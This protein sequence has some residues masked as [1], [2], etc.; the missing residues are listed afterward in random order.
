MLLS[1]AMITKNEEKNIFRSLQALKRLENKIEYEIVVVDTGSTDNTIEIAKK[2]TDKV[3]KHPWTG[4]FAEMRNISISYCQG[5]WI[6]ILDADEVIESTDEI[7]DFLK[8]N[9]SEIYNCMTLKSKNIVTKNEDDYIIMDLMRL[10]KNHKDFRYKGRV[11]EQPFLKP[12]IG[13]SRI[14]FLHYGYCRADYN[15]MQYKF[16]RNLELLLKD[17]EEGNK[18]IYNYFQVAQTYGMSEKHSESLEYIKIAYNMIGN[19]RSEEKSYLY[20]NH[21]YSMMEYTVGN[22]ERAIEL[23]EEALNFNKDHL[24]FYFILISAYMKMAKYKEADKYCD[25]YLKLHDKLS[26]G[27]LVNDVSVPC[28]T[29]CKKD[30]ILKNKILCNYN[31]KKFR[32][33]PDLFKKIKKENYIDELKEIY[34]FSLLKNKEYAEVYAYLKNIKFEDKDIQS[35]VN[36]LDRFRNE[37]EIDEILTNINS[38]FELDDRLNTLRDVLYKKNIDAYFD[39]SIELETYFPWKSKYLMELLNNNKF[40]LGMLKESNCNNIVQYVTNFVSDYK[41]I[42]ILCKYSKTHFYT[43]DLKMLNLITSI[44][45]VLVVNNSINSKEYHELL[46]RARINKLNYINII[47]NKSILKDS[48]YDKLFGENL[49][50]WIEISQLIKFYENDKLKVVRLLKQLLKKYPKYNKM[51]EAFLDD[52]NY[53]I[54]Q[55]MIEEKENLLKAAEELICNGMIDEALEILYELDNIFK[56]EYNIL[57]LKG[58]AL[59][60]KGKYENALLELTVANSIMEDN[61]ECIYNIGCVCEAMEK[62]EEAKRYYKEAY[63]LTEDEDMKKEIL[64]LIKQLK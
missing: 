49:L 2:F 62:S 57:N 15:I 19:K 28:N 9:D 47:Y 27:Y 8:G 60:S 30:T 55:E 21:L 50:I 24:D 58:V 37:G 17:L 23:A 34:I 52:I 56:Y 35:I 59:Y 11:H 6:L 46:Q 54:N 3:Y 29:F 40:E 48:N 63:E 31:E 44:E 53:N 1:I 33:V 13:I 18:T 16:E 20:V 39:D 61:F 4:N 45:D 43:S 12:P 41:C 26:K 25:E 42:S 36:I 14:S 38:I 64:T 7:V 5:K 22:N 10:F 32:L 51:I